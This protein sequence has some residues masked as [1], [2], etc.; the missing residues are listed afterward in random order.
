MITGALAWTR[1][2]REE[3]AKEAG[4]ER[5]EETK[6]WRRT[7]LEKEIRKSGTVISMVFHANTSTPHSI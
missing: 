1:K 2:K 7:C 3:T 5:R 4:K 6:T